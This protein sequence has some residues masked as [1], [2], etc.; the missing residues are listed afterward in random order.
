MRVLVIDQDSTLLTAITRLLGSYFTIDAVTTKADCQDLVRCNEYDVIVAGERLED[1]SGLE[2]LSQMARSRPDMLRIFAVEPARLKLLRGRLGP[3]GLFR[4]LSYPIEPRQL[5]AALSAAAGVDEETEEAGE[6]EEAAPQLQTPTRV[7]AVTTAVLGQTGRSAATAATSA[8]AAAPSP[9]G[10]ATPRQPSRSRSS[11]RPRQP[12]SEALAVGA[13]LAASRTKTKSLAP[14]SL[15]AS[16]KRSAY[17]VG[18]GVAIVVGALILAFRIFSPPP[19]HTTSLNAQSPSFPPEVLKLVADTETAFQLDDLRGA[20]TDIAALQQIAPT[21]P[22]LPFFESELKRRQAEAAASRPP[23]LPSDT[24]TKRSTSKATIPPAP[25]LP[26]PR[27]RPS[28]GGVAF[29]GTTLEDTST[30]VG[31]TSGSNA[32]QMPP[33]TGSRAPVAAVMTHE[34]H[35]VRRV[36]AE[37]PKDAERNGIEGTV[38]L[39]FSI[40]KHGDVYD[41][42]VLHAEPSNIFNRAAIAA[43]RRWKY[44]PRTIDGIPVEARVKVRVTF[45]LDD[46]R[47]H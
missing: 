46:K 30:G 10:A 16:A 28:G 6:L 17:T 45:K 33:A 8:R 35:V 14:P 21:H 32:P 34:A 36:P 19:L 44:E 11:P 47:G 12:T 13:R 37:Y 23:V 24:A 2:L 22:G 15:E 39:G 18:A 43:V 38:D 27:R 41:I 4:T 1:G 7:S 9:A 40:S 20:R 29:S 26:P 25:Q 31:S 5:L 42:T 3:F